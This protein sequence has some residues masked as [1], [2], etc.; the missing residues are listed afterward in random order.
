MLPWLPYGT[1][2]SMLSIY[3]N[4]IPPSSPPPKERQ[5]CLLTAQS[6]EQD[7]SS[8]QE[9]LGQARAEL[10]TTVSKN[11][12]LKRA[13]DE[14]TLQLRRRVS[15]CSYILLHTID[16]KTISFVFLAIPGGRAAAVGGS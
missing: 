3:K 15:P 1:S 4:S 8:L 6:Q 10:K 12:E 11:T 14:I 16:M 5:Q 13:L 7:L 9:A 2:S